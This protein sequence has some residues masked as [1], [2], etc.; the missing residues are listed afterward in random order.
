MST[1][2]SKELVASIF[3]VKNRPSKELAL[4]S[5]LLATYFMWISCLAFSAT[6]MVEVVFLQILG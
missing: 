6:L 3:R 2:G 4:S 5:W 1:T